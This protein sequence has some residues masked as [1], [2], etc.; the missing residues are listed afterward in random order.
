MA[1]SAHKGTSAG[2]EGVNSS[3]KA[4]ALLYIGVWIISAWFLIWFANV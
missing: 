3:S 2:K 1:A 4:G